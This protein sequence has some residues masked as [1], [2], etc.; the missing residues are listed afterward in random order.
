MNGNGFEAQRQRRRPPTRAE[1][2]RAE[3]VRQIRDRIVGLRLAFPGALTARVIV[4]DARDP[5]S[6]LH[7]CFDWDN[8]TASSAD[9]LDA[10]EQLIAAVE[11][12]QAIAG[13]RTN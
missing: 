4:Q 5:E 3:Q 10:A 11:A 13:D 9:R 6:P 1:Q 2:R 7:A 8:D 12:A